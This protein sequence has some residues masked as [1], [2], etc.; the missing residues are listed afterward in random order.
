MRLIITRHGETEENKSG[1]IQGHLPGVLSDLGKEQARKLAERLKD[2]RI[3]L[4]V[5]S[6]LARAADTSREI[7]R[8]HD[9]EVVFDERLRE[10]HLGE[11]QGMN[12]RYIDWDNLPENVESIESVGKRAFDLFREILEKYNGKTVLFVGHDIINSV[13]IAK[14]QGANM[15]DYRTYK[16]GNTC[17]NILDVDQSGKV[18][19]KLLNCTRHLNEN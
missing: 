18:E 19:L 7:A 1:I 3:D 2:E 14:L 17:L 15:D 13:L 4:I 12:N 6:D 8:F 11:L 10:N 5:S 16:Q 9:V